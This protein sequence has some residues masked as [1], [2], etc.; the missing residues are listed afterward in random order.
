MEPPILE[1]A[2]FHGV[3]TNHLAIDASSYLTCTGAANLEPSLDDADEVPQPEDIQS[4]LT[5]KHSEKLDIGKR[6]A[7]L[8]SSIIK[9]PSQ[10]ES[11]SCEH[12]WD[13]VLPDY[14]GIR[15]MKVEEPILRHDHELDM[16]SFRA[17]VSLDRVDLD[18][19]LEPID[20]ERDEGLAF[21]S[22]CQGLPS[23]MQERTTN[24]K[25]DCTRETLH[26]ME[27][28][29]DPLTSSLQDVHHTLYKNMT[30]RSKVNPTESTPT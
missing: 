26:F 22:Y 4:M 7:L 25:L 20:D 30:C 1:Y 17:Q 29:R 15:R 19:P 2:R 13:G 16:L 14:R 12:G 6:E 5:E 18:L 24:E 11:V 28:I 21:P 10:L 23:Q 3:A 27:K 9:A 8:L